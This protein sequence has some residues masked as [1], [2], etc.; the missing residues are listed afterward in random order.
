MKYFKKTSLIMGSVA[1]F[2]AICIQDAFAWQA[3]TA[4]I[5]I[6]AT[7]TREMVQFI[8][9]CLAGVC[10]VAG[11]VVAGLGWGNDKKIQF[12]KYIGGVMAAAIAIS[13]YDTWAPWIGL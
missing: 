12:L 10:I 7:E 11:A 1:L 6:K 8:F 4:P 2:T 5:E 3:F 9:K 13:N